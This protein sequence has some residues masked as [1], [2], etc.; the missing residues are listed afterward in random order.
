MRKK[1]IYYF[2]TQYLWS[3]RKENHPSEQIA[4]K[5]EKLSQLTNPHFVI[6]ELQETEQMVKFQSFIEDHIDDLES[7]TDYYIKTLLLIRELHDHQIVIPSLFH[8]MKK[9][10]F[11][12]HKSAS[13]PYI[14]RSYR[15]LYSNFVICDLQRISYI[16]SF[17]VP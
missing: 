15:S 14:S 6:H 11:S 7:I 17:P 8:S 13:C 2:Q 16:L 4:Q 1:N 10:W 9:R 3:I 12:T 5:E